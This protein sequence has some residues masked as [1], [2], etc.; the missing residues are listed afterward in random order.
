VTETVALSYTRLV[1]ISA[2]DA[3]RTVEVTVV[4]G[5]S[6]CA[7]AAGRQGHARGAALPSLPHVQGLTNPPK[8]A[9]PDLVPLPSWGI[10]T[11]HT[12][13]GRD[14][15]NFAATVWIGGSSRLEVE[16]FARRARQS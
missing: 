4:T 3:T 2:R 12:Q 9:L 16:G 7:S 14:L 5:H 15:L 13:S 1:H 8:A 11:S 10:S 6:C